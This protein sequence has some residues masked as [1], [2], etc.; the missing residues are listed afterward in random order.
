MHDR[1]R[2][3][4]TAASA[5]SMKTTHILTVLRTHLTFAPD[6]RRRGDEHGA[7]DWTPEVSHALGDGERIIADALKH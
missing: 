7:L 5:A 3:P 6:A 1:P 4:I 2:Y